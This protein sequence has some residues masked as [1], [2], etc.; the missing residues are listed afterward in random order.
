M[1]SRTGWWCSAGSSGAV[2][3]S[4]QHRPGVGGDRDPV[5]AHLLP[6]GR[7]LEVAGDR[8]PGAAG[9][10]AADAHQ[11][12]RRVVDRGHRVDGV[13]VGERRRRGGRERR[14]RPA[15]VGEPVG[16]GALAL[17]GEE[18][19]GEVRGAAGV[20]PVPGRQLH[21][22]G[23]DPLHVDHL[24]AE[25][26]LLAAAAEHEHLRRTRFQGA[27]GEL[28]V[29]DD[30]GHLA[31]LGLAGDRSVGAHQHGDRAEP[32][33]RRDHREAARPGAHQHADVLAL[34][35]ADRDQ[36][37]DDGVDPVLRRLVGVGA[38]LEQEEV[39][40][41]VCGRPARRAAGRARRGC[42]APAARAGR[43]AEA[44]P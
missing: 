25:V 12:A 9:D 11:Q 34:V 22:V 14:Q 8:Q 42:A 2:A 17:A 31:E 4:S 37:A 19:E 44:G 6:E 24:A 41:R 20:G 32:V 7:R 36:T 38:V 30:P 21:L 1:N 28:G 3:I 16:P 15:A 23:I 33:E 40:P 27:G 43:G 39:A 10:R 13:V 18:D 5:A 26:A 29:G 35:D